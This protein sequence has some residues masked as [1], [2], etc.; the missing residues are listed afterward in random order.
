MVTPQLVEYIKNTLG[1]GYAEDKVQDAL[2]KKGWKQAD[3]DEAFRIARGT[4]AAAPLQVQS[5]A[6]QQ[7][8][9][10]GDRIPI[11]TA[12]TTTWRDPLSRY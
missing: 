2:V 7:T 12:R 10:T 3:V 1:R 4:A 8:P 11:F 9:Q 6:G 5:V